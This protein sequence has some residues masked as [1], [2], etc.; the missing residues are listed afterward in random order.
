MKLLELLNMRGRHRYKWDYLRSVLNER[1]VYD[2]NAFRVWYAPGSGVGL[3]FAA[4]QAQ[5]RRRRAADAAPP[6]PHDA[7]AA[8]G[9][10]RHAARS[11]DLAF[12]PC[13]HRR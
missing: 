12:P 9:A 8:R 7:A 2:D 13:R 10:R 5:V 1:V 6:A 4:K 11:V 3:L